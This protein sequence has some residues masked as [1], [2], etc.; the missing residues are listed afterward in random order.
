M[1]ALK[2]S[3]ILQL[4]WEKQSLSATCDR[5]FI[6]K[7]HCLWITASSLVWSHISLTR[8]A[9]LTCH[10]DL[11]LNHFSPR[12]YQHQINP[13]TK[14][15]FVMSVFKKKFQ[16]LK[17][18]ITVVFCHFVPIVEMLSLCLLLRSSAVYS[19][20]SYVNIWGIFCSWV[21]CFCLSLKG[22][23]K[24]HYYKLL[25]LSSFTTIHP[26]AM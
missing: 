6:M 20:H 17:E 3:Q 2:K 9:A 24:M 13:A 21:V 1:A 5:F 18:N 25:L 7:F 12:E 14:W 26:C 16:T 8:G 19:Q 4:F 23:I 10:R 22:I 15:L 11:F